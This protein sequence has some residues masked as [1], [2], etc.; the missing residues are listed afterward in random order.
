MSLLTKLNQ[1]RHFASRAWALSAPYFGSDEKWRARGLLAA[2]VALNLGAV[3]MLVLLNEWNRVFYDALQNKNAEVFWQQ[4]ARFTGLAFGY[5]LI[6]VYRFYLTQLLEI[7]WRAWMTAHV[8]ARWLGHKAF[9]RL[10]LMRFTREDASLP[11]NPDQRI[12]E[13]L[14]MFTASAVG[15]SMGLL[16]ACVT[17]ASFVGILW[18]LSGSFGFAFNGSDWNIPG[19]MVWMA[20]AYALVGSVLTH[21]IGR[22]LISLNFAQQKREADFRHHLVRVREY[23]EAIA[24]DRG[25]PVEQRQLGGHFSAVLQNT[26]ALIKTQKRLTWFTVGFGQ[27]A[28]VFPFVV[29]AP[30]FFSGAIQLGELMQIASAFGRVQ[31]ALSWFVDNY[32]ALARWRAT[33]D[34]LTGFEDSLKAANSHDTLTAGSGDTLRLKDLTLSLPDGSVLLQGQGLSLR[35][36][37]SVLLQGP[38]GSGKSSLFRT[39]AGIWPYARGHVELPAGFEQDAMFLPQR[40]YFPN[41]KLRDALAYP[42]QADRYSDAELQQA[43]CDALLPQLAD[44]LDAED[45]WGQKLSGGEQQRLAIARALLKQPRWLFADE[46]TSALDAAAEQQVYEKLLGLIRQHGGALVSIA[47]RPSVAAFHQRQWTVEASGRLTG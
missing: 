15:L 46:A 41:G 6:A 20:I 11:D 31:D 5:I 28:V 13:D 25:E 47:H 18:G 36:G 34:R 22:P 23:S 30:R 14:G 44:K 17:L 27:A 32:D 12:Q 40:P 38:S 21:Y 9:Y 35:P 19:F 2:I 7:R 43:L 39:L 24:L 26:L 10:E 42:A 29:A 45:A 1:F 3:Y 37:D 4:L 8:M 33:T 16:N